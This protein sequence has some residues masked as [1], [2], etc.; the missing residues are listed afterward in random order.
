MKNTYMKILWISFLLAI[1]NISLAQKPASTTINNNEKK[2]NSGVK[3]FLLSA[4]NPPYAWRGAPYNDSDFVYYKNA[5]FYNFMWARDEDELMNKIHQ[6]HFKFFVSIRQLFSEEDSNGVDILRGVKYWDDG[7]ETYNEPVTEIS[8]LMLK[9]VDTVVQKYKDDPSLIGYWICDEPFPSAYGNI[10]KLIARIKEKDPLHYSLVNIGDNEYTTDDNIEYFIDTTKVEVLCY[11]RYNFFNGFDLNKEYFERLFMMRKH[12]LMHNIPFYNTVQAVGTNG[13]S[14][15][16]LDWRTPDS[17]EHRW[18]VYTSLTYGVHGL[19][20]FHWDAEDWG[21]FQNPDRDKIYPS[22]QSINAEIDSLSQIMAGLTTTKVYHL[23]QH[24]NTPDDIIKSVSNDENIIV[25]V[26]EDEESKENYFMLMNA[27]FSG[28]ISAE[29]TMNNAVE[30]LKVFNINDNKWEEVQYVNSDSGATFPINL[31]KGSGKLFNFKRKNVSNVSGYKTLPAKFSLDQNFPNPF[32][33]TTTI[34]Y[35]IANVKK[36]HA[37]S[38]Q[39]QLK[40]YDVLGREAATLVNEKQP[41]GAYQITFD[42][43]N[44]SSG[45]YFYKLTAGKFS[46]IKKFLLLK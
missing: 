21:V 30:N 27:G 46:A 9:K 45:I 18:L 19:I 32:N 25:G 1:V 24:T 44:L 12:A 41:A 6:F 33:P 11:D 36:L 28:N 42:A 16:E 17:T 26:F 10:A 43:S 7:N 23:Q 35:T 13:T 2:I 34:R 4:Y 22:L 39:V 14:A 3:G 37:T 8:E 38:Q 5:N 40:I 20:W 31:R 29:V 15:E